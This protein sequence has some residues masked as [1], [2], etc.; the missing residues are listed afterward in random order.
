M[1]VVVCVQN[2]SCEDFDETLRHADSKCVPS[3]A[4][5][6][7]LTQSALASSLL[8]SLF[9]RPSFIIHLFQDVNLRAREAPSSAG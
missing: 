7:D 2:K 3:C 9:Q 8:H 5:G 1:I 4:G 6:R